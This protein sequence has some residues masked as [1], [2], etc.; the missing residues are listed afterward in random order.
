MLLS[1]A[2]L[3]LYTGWR[4]FWFITDDAYIAFRYV[5][6]SV[7]GHG[8][9]WNPEPFR[10]VEGYTSFLWVALLD[11]VWRVFKVEPPSSANV[12]SLIFAFGSIIVAALTAFRFQLSPPLERYRLALV[13]LVVAGLL[14]NP[15]F[16][17]WAS[18]GL[19]TAMFNFFLLCWVA[20]TIAIPEANR[21]RVAAITSS[22]ALTYLARPDGILMILGTILLVVA[23]AVVQLKR[24]EK[25]ANFVLSLSPI[26]IP[27]VHLVWRRFYYGE[28]LPNTYYAKQVAAWPSAGIRYLLSFIIEYGLWFWIVLMTVVAGYLIRKQR[29][30]IRHSLKSSRGWSVVVVVM[31]I[32]GHLGYYTFVVGGD[33]FEW[34]V[35]SHVFPLLSFALIYAVRTLQLTAVKSLGTMVAALLISLPIPWTYHN[36]EKKILYIPISSSLKL[37]ISDKIPFLAAPLAKL[38]DNLQGWL[39]DHLICVRRQKHKLFFEN[40]LRVFPERTFDI[41]VRS[42]KFPVGKFSTVGVAGWTLPNVNILDGYGLNDY[43]VARTPVPEEKERKMAHDR[44]SPPHYFASFVPNV[45]IMGK[46]QIEYLARRPDLELTE[47]KIKAIEKYWEEKIVKKSNPPD[48]LAPWPVKPGSDTTG[49]YQ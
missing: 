3:L 31:T 48:S 20:S 12:L 22:A 42:G 46:R 30:E 19:E 38:Q 15:T 9:V 27:G 35:Y 23:V 32:L 26:L 21:F 44:L 10:A 13:I 24:R 6:N 25:V 37:T 43:I 4:E 40:Q 41:P 49:L 47:E 39:S 8:Y 17:T 11:A 34:R 1:I 33:H 5:S 14:V 28:W 36:L 45:P 29:Q 18:S 16:L 7:H 2:A